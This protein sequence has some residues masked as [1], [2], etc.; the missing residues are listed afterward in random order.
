MF[1]LKAFNAL[2]AVFEV[3]DQV[4]TSQKRF[5]YNRIPIKVFD[6]FT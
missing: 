2:A 1:Y 3:K 4:K 6:D 5:C